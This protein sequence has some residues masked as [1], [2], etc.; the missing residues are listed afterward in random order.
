MRGGSVVLWLSLG[1]LPVAGGSADLQVGKEINEVCAGCHGEFGQGGKEGK[2]PRIAGQ[3]AA[4]IE[5]QMH[6]FRDRKR[7]NMPMLEHVDERQMP[8]QDIADVAAYLAGIELPTRLP[9]VEPD[10]FDAYERLLQAKRVLNIPRAEGDVERGRKL[11]NRECRSCHGRRG[12]GKESQGFPMLAGQYTDYLWRQV[13][14]YLNKVRIHDEDAPDDELLK[15]FSQDELRDIFAY[16]SVVD[17][18]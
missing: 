15:E 8:D 14:K 7:P 10:K 16:M 4:F 2:Y 17:D 13:E 11:Y 9:P 18:E 5:K 6:L 1:C 3:P 12:E